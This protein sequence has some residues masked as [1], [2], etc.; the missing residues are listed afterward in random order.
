M[1]G[2]YWEMVVFS[3]WD[4]DEVQEYEVFLSGLG[5]KITSAFALCSQ[6]RL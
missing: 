6:S 1:Q 5:H 4:S 2:N 3:P